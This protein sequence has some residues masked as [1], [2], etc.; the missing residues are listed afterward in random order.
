[1]RSRRLGALPACLAVIGAMVAP[2]GA[3]IGTQ[4]VACSVNY[5]ASDWGGAG[6][7]T[8]NLH[9][10]NLGDTL[11]GWT[12]SFAFP[13]N[14]S[15]TQPGWSA[16]WA[17]A[18]GSANVTATNLDWNRTLTANQ[19]IDIG[20]N[21]TFTGTANVAP[22]SFAIN[23]TTCAGPNQSPSASLTSPAS[24]SSFTAGANIPLAAT[25]AD[26]DGTVA[27]VDFFAGN[28]LIGTDTSSPYN[29]TWPGVAVGNYVLSAVA[30]DNTG[31]TTQSAPVDVTVNPDTGPSI[32]AAPAA[33]NVPE[34]RTATV[35]VK[36][37]RQPAANVTVTTARTSGDT[38]LSVS[39]GAS[40]GFTTAN[41]DV[42]QNV[43]LAAAEDA[44]SVNRLGTS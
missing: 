31:A 7:F 20:F 43:T 3:D 26:A 10:T 42:A 40:L 22:T 18:A 27:K 29:V 8:A 33:V 1:M 39:A 4:A 35:A 2:A 15:V 28:T 13:G 11:N 24:G 12:L 16:T 21:G 9:V 5:S 25:A 44:G 30:T 6:G 19:A 37:S 32:V 23:G 34:G 14:Q 38:D 36:L 17:Q 41:W